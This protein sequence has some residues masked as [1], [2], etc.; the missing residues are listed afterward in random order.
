V[1]IAVAWNPRFERMRGDEPC[2]V[3]DLPHVGLLAAVHTL[4]L[5]A[6]DGR[7][8]LQVFGPDV[9]DEGDSAAG[10]VCAHIPPIQKETLPSI[11]TIAYHN[12]LTAR[13]QWQGRRYA[14]E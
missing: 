12:D 3:V 11:M 7:R 9:H 5:A 4:D 6:P 2:H 1:T 13:L 14:E 10:K 8:L